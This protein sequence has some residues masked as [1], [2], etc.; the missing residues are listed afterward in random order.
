MNMLAKNGPKGDDWP[1]PNA[2]LRYIGFGTEL[3]VLLGLGV[4]GGIK[5]DRYWN[6][7]PL[8]TILFPLIGLIFS[9]RKL[10]QM[11]QN[12]PKKRR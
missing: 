12:K 9:F 3:L 5:L 2:A 11:L 10:Y 7:L 4:W 1:K 8:F 6:C